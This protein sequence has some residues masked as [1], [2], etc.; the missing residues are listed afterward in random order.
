MESLALL[1]VIILFSSLLGGPT[2]LLLTYV[3]DKPKSIRI[4][5]TIVI[6]ALALVGILFG[7][8]LALGSSIPTIPRLIGAVGVLT[9]ITALLYEFKILKRKS[10]SD[11][12]TFSDSVSENASNLDTIAVNDPEKTNYYAVI[13]TSKRQDANHDSYY[14]HNDALVEKIKSLSGY[15]SH[16]SIRHPETRE[17]MTVAYFDSLEAIDAW[18]NDETHKAAKKLAKSDFYEDYSVEITKVIDKYGWDV[19]ATEHQ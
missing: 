16:K 8:Q 17:G 6:C 12:S 9:S 10:K 13:F 7:Y 14:Q 19:Q 3:P 4:L 2:A 15:R 18:R 1:A 11:Q 5:R